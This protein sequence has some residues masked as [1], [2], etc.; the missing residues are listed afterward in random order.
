[1]AN[2]TGGVTGSTGAGQGGTGTGV[3]G[4]T[5]PPTSGNPTVGGGTAKPVTITAA[6]L[7]ALGFS[8]AQ[9]N[10]MPQGIRN[11]IGNSIITGIGAP[12]PPGIISP[13]PSKIRVGTTYKWIWKTSPAAEEAANTGLG[14]VNNPNPPTNNWLI[15]LLA[16]LVG[17]EVIDLALGIDIVGA[18]TGTGEITGGLEAGGGAAAVAEGLS[19]TFPET[20]AEGVAWDALPQGVLLGS[21]YHAMRYAFVAALPSLRH[22]MD[23]LAHRPIG[24]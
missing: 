4:S 18:G 17:G 20:V 5:G 11:V 14:V 24:G 22:Q 13:T 12:E 10:A 23:L 15:D 6:D 16:G 3:S 9:V 7:L 19:L 1:M 21:G 8:A 2:G